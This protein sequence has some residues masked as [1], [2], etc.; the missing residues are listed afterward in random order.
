M[1]PGKLVIVSSEASTEQYGMIVRVLSSGET[2][3]SYIV[4][5]GAELLILTGADIAEI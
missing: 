4:L 5:V 2:A 3:D 1:L